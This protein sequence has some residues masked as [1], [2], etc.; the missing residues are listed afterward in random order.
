MPTTIR[1]TISRGVR[2][3]RL[4]SSLMHPAR[5]TATLVIPMRRRPRHLP[6]AIRR[7][8]ATASS[9]RRKATNRPLRA[10][11]LITD[12]PLPIIP[13]LRRAPPPHPPAPGPARP[14]L[15]ITP[16][17]HDAGQGEPAANGGATLVDPRNMAAFPPE[18]RPETGPKKQLPPQFRR[19]LVD[20]STKEPAGTIII[21]TPNTYL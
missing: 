18:V 21:D 5:H 12:R 14:P 6:T 9:K 10:R 1:S 13:R 16:G 17:Y 3:R 7:S 19:T 15:P 20:Y 4:R 8:R 11:V 2:F